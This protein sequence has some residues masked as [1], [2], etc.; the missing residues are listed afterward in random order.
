MGIAEVVAKI[1]YAAAD[2]RLLVGLELDQV[3]R[4]NAL[5]KVIHLF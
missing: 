1:S 3:I 2:I 4:V 5:N